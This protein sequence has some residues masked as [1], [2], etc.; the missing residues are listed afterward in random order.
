MSKSKQPFKFF[1]YVAW[2]YD[3]LYQISR[4]VCIYFDLATDKELFLYESCFF[5]IL[6]S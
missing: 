3:M 2:Y 5:S 4:T 1:M 6:L